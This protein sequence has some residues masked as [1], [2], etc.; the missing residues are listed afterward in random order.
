MTPEERLNQL[1]PLLS[2]TTAILDRHTAQLRQH[3][4]LLKQLVQTTESNSEALGQVLAAQADLRGELTQLNGHLS[5][6]ATGT[7]AGESIQEQVG[8]VESRLEVLENRLET[9]G[10]KMDLILTKLIRVYINN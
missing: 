2:E 4:G 7:G 6:L 10:G 8:G 3:A 9:L 1:E 5:R